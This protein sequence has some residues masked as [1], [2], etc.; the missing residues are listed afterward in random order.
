MCLKPTLCTRE[1]F[2]KCNLSQNLYICW[3][4]IYLQISIDPGNNEKQNKTFWKCFLHTTVSISYTFISNTMVKFLII[5]NEMCEFSFL[6]LPLVS[7]STGKMIFALSEFK[8]LQLKIKNYFIFQGYYC[9]R[10][11]FSWYSQVN[12][13]LKFCRFL[14]RFMPASRSVYI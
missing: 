9:L 7:Y 3:Q 1:C 8:R 5:Y 13:G 4:I 6:F 11:K 10:V 14:E 2:S 12:S